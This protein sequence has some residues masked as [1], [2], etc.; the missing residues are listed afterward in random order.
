MIHISRQP[1]PDRQRSHSKSHKLHKQSFIS[2]KDAG[3][4]DSRRKTDC[5]SGVGAVG[6]SEGA[7]VVLEPEEGTV[8]QDLDFFYGRIVVWLRRNG[9]PS[10]AVLPLSGD[11]LQAFRRSNTLNTSDKQC[12]LAAPLWC[13][14]RRRP[15]L[16]R[17]SIHAPHNSDAYNLS[18]T[19]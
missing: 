6:G 8:I 12:G 5:S 7:S 9:V 19:L 11:S 10:L 4:A 1:S 13:P 16:V 2:L 15:A 14:G 3:A 18:D 17:C